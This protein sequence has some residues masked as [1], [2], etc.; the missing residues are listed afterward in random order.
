MCLYYH[1]YYDHHYFC[2]IIV[3]SII[4]IIIQ[5][6]VSVLYLASVPGLEAEIHVGRVA[7]AR[8]ALPVQRRLSNTA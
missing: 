8:A 5:C 2:I 6:L 7:S 1:Y 3:I 4:I